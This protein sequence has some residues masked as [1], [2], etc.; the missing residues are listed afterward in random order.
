MT[1]PADTTLAAAA[2]AKGVPAFLGNGLLRPFRRDVKNDFASAAGVALVS[3]C[4]GQVLGTKASSAAGVGEVP[5][6]PEFGSRLHLLRHKNNRDTLGDFAVVL[7]E[8]AL[9][10]WEPRARVARAEVL[11]GA[12]DRALNLRVV[13]DVVDQTGRLLAAAQDV[14][15]PVPL[16]AV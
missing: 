2:A 16:S 10:R 4:V 12:D 9:R 14:T 7:V 13:F 11:P 5:W 6:R 3:S 8:E 1:L 15:V